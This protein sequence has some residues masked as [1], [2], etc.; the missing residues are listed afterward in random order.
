MPNVLRRAAMAASAA[1][2]LTVA[3]SVPVVASASTITA[4]AAKCGYTQA[5]YGLH[6]VNQGPSDTVKTTSPTL[7]SF[8]TDLA[9]FDSESQVTFTA[10]NYPTVK[11]T[12]LTDDA[13]MT[14]I[15][16]TGEANLQAD[17]AAHIDETCQLYRDHSVSLVGYSM[18]AWVINDWLMKHKNEWNY[19]DTVILYGDPCWHNSLFNYGLAQLFL[20]GYGC[21]PVSTYPYPEAKAHV[22]F[23][24]VSYS[25]NLDPISGDGWQGG[26]SEYT[27]A[28]QLAAALNCW[29]GVVCSHLDYKI[30]AKGGGQVYDGA[31]LVGNRFLD[32][33]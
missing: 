13:A 18:G 7:T 21:V 24:I 6:G 12:S 10:V 31:K 8:K 19:I 22:P 4:T 11:V 32:N 33:S 28:A 25:L 14:I 15:M 30:G 9:K 17:I 16:N 2:A 5:V 3:V 26:L 29:S 20:D 1:A 27:Q 23:P